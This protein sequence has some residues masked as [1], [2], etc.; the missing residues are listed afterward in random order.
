[1]PFNSWKL[2]EKSLVEAT[3]VATPNQLELA[4]H[5]GIAISPKM[6]TRVAAS[7]LRVALYRELCL[8]G[9]SPISDNLQ[10]LF[11]G[12]A[13]AS[14]INAKPK[15]KEEAIAWI[16]HMRL[17]L[18]LKHL[19]RLKVN[20][21]DVV[22]RDNNNL[23]EV[24]SIGANGKLH[25]KGGKGASSWPDR[26]LEVV[27]RSNDKSKK[28]VDARMHAANV[29]SVRSANAEWSMAKSSDLRS[30]QVTAVPT[31]WE[32]DELELV[33]RESADEKPVQAF[34]EKYPHL[35]TGLLTGI[36]RFCIPQKRLGAEYVP[37]FLVCDVN[38]I[39]VRWVMIEL[40]TPRCG[41]YLSDGKSLNKNVRKGTNQITEW[42]GWLE[43]NRAYAQRPKAQ[44]GLGLPGILS[45][46]EALVIVGQREYLTTVTDTKRR[47][48]YYENNVKVHTYDWLLTQLRGAI[49]YSGPP[50]S[51]PYLLSRAELDGDNPLSELET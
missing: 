9:V 42:R 28:A 17:S 35:L 31:D 7:M 18:R 3:Q 41:I 6:P 22:L 12:V 50:R 33:I 27:A 30:F 29:A 37:D 13:T 26:I 39:G 47:E 15:N 5:A 11:D 8:E 46:S 40:E 23:E 2:A 16:E 44:E 25:F 10:E 20:A 51:N 45:R 1:M 49:R 38:S 36:E 32:I 14:K 48:L 21:G 24:T 43:E 34:L 19:R 4:R